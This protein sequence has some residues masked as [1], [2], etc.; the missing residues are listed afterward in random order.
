MQ[1]YKK[2]NTNKKFLNQDVRLAWTMSHILYS[3]LHHL[4]YEAG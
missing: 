4:F 2:K 1:C 3:K